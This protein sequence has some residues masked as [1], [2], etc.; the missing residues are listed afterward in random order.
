MLFKGQQKKQQKTRTPRIPQKEA[1]FRRST[2]LT[3]STSSAVKAAGEERAALKSER[4]VRQELKRKQRRIMSILFMTICVVFA[5]YYLLSQFIFSVVAVNY[6]NGIFITQPPTSQYIESI[7]EYLRKNPGERFTFSLSDGN[8][9]TYLQSKYPE[10]LDV[11]N[12]DAKSF[13]ISLRQPVAAWSIPGGKKNFVD[14]DGETFSRNVYNE[15]PVR[16]NDTTGASAISGNVVASKSFLRFLGRIVSLTN[17]SGVG[18]VS[19]AT[20]PPN[21]T[22]EID[23]RLE[24]R[25]YLVKLHTDRDPA[26]EVEDLKRVDQYLI[27]KGIK[28]QYI[29]LRISGKAYYK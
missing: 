18:T 2:T 14:K 10:I 23:V 9:R 17:Q 20:L 15:P 16:V 22:R 19:E 27:Q 28:P 6:Q 3:G 21:T 4:L 24:G 8:V 1:S 13:T 11:E 7:N 12:I 29:D 25:D 5:I 26:Q